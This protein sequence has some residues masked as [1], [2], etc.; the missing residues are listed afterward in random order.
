MRFFALESATP[1]D[2]SIESGVEI[3]GESFRYAA[4]VGAGVSGEGLLVGVNLDV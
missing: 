1:C 2:G 4:A 3:T